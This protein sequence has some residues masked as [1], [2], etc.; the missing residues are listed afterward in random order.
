MK[1]VI[2]VNT[3]E[4][5][6][7]FVYA[8]HIGL[9]AQMKSKHP[10]M[11]ILFY[12]PYR[13]SIDNMRNAV[14]QIA[15]EQEADYIFFIDDDV[16]VRNDTFDSLL[17]ADKD[18]ICALTYVR[19]YPFH[20]MFFKD[21]LTVQQLNGKVRKDL[22]FHDDYENSVGEDGLVRTGAVGFSCVLIKTDILRAMTPPYFV[23]GPGHTEDVYFCLKARAEL[24]PEPEIWVDTK[25]PVGHM[26]MPDMVTEK[27]VKKL[28]EMYKPEEDSEKIQMDMRKPTGLLGILRK[29]GE[30][31][32]PSLNELEDSDEGEA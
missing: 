30:Q 14:A 24:E 7:S 25:V 5:V 17:A 21:V 15:I 2:G 4:N 11:E 3:L 26:L 6:S 29:L 28:R 32:S 9:I 18:I 1:I 12:T 20:P 31:Q 13:M 23:T 19:G 22:T 10:D 16:V 27:T 8:S